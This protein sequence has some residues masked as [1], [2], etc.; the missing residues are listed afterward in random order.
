M[1][2]RPLA[3]THA[4][5]KSREVLMCLQLIATTPIQESPDVSA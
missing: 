4:L 1:R 3:T 5:S 2:S